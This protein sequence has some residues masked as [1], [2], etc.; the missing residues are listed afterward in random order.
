MLN[1][2]ND[3]PCWVDTRV[4]YAY[5]TDAGIIRAPF[6][7]GTIFLDE[8]ERLDFDTISA[9]AGYYMHILDELEAHR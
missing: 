6:R 3:P 4:G 2:Q 7:D 9:N 8:Q 1:Q 5:W